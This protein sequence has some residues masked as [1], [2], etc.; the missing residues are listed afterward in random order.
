MHPVLDRPAPAASSAVDSTGSV[1]AE[2]A[3]PSSGR[4][5][6]RYFGAGA[7]FAVVALL[8]TVVALL[9]LDRALFDMPSLTARLP[10]DDPQTPAGKL[11]L[12]D[13]YRD[14]R[15]LFLGDSRILYGVDPAIV[16]RT[17]ECGPGF[18]G[19]FSA[20][21]PRLTR[22]MA[23]RLLDKMSPEVVV[24]GVSQWELSDAARI[25][26]ETPAPHLVPPWQ[27]D[28]YGVN[29]EQ[30]E[31]VDATVGSV[32][33]LYRYRHDVREALEDPT[34][35]DDRLRQRGFL[36]FDGPRR[37]GEQELKAREEQWFTD[38]ATGGRR[39]DALR[40][41]IAD[42]RERDI[43]VLL[44]APPLHRGFHDRVRPEVGAFR[45]ALERVAADGDALFEDLT[46]PQRAGI[47]RDE[48]EDIV[49]LDDDGAEKLSRHLGRV[50]AS[51]LDVDP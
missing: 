28:D 32:W 49:H 48:F 27:L 47:D 37:L 15:L 4:G 44:V 42:L 31:L 23:D 36:E 26:L 50:I 41:L 38:F 34:P 30:G 43:Q 40:D 1:P 35:N 25:K 10:I 24:I 14:A 18:N 21:D 5:P 9:L 13:R 45:A 51:R 20:A 22:I 46:E 11:L 6:W 8:T 16:S 2:A 3:R 29:L 7:R 19:A 12:A 33:R 17:C 39:E